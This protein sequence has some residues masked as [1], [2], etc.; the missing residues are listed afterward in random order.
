MHPRLKNE[1]MARGLI[2]YPGLGTIDG[3]RGHHVLLAPPF[4]VTEADLETITDRLASALDA[5]LAGLSRRAA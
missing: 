2:C 4:I 5:A 3:K 1:A